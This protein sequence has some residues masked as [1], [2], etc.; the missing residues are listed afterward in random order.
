VGVRTR[1]YGW[2]LS[3][4]SGGKDG[5]NSLSRIATA[6]KLLGTTCS[7]AYTLARVKELCPFVEGKG[8]VDG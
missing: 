2:G 4:G 5:A 3:V 1:W 6:T 7:I 8:G